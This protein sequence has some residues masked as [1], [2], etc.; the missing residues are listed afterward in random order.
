[1]PESFRLYDNK[2]C[3][4]FFSYLDS[5]EYKEIIARDGIAFIMK[6]G[7]DIHRGQGIN[8]ISP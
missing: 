3:R 1:M 6:E 7:R 5:N 4:K 8:L 2:E